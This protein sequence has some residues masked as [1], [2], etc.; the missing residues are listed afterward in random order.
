[1]TT[2]ELR[3]WG[4]IWIILGPLGR[5]SPELPLP[6]TAEVPFVFPIVSRRRCH[7]ASR[8]IAMFYTASYSRAIGCVT[9]LLGL[10]L[11]FSGT[12]CNSG[13]TRP[14]QE[15]RF[16]LYTGTWRGNINGLEVVL[17]MR[18]EQGFGLPALGGTGTALNSARGEIHRLTISGFGTIDDRDGMAAFFNIFTADEIGP[19]GVYLSFGKHT[20]ALSGNVSRDGRTWPGRWTSTTR[21]D[22]API[23][24]S[25][26]HSVMLIKE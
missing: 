13:P 2:R 22:G 5:S 12:A 11:A 21:D 8:G 10:L 15:D 6:Q 4:L 1:V 19:G 14:T 20:G 17:D 24:G 16:G 9:V 7:F 3:K 25:G 26:E 23:F 18:A